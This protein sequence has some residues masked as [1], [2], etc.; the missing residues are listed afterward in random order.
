[1]QCLAKGMVGGMKP[2]PEASHAE[3]FYEVKIIGEG[4]DYAAACALPKKE[5]L[6]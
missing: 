6:T 4:V 5:M 1:M 2:A 3:H